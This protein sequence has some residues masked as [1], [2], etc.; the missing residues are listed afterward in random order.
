MH[1]TSGRHELTQH[2]LLL[3]HLS[4]QLQ[5]SAEDNEGAWTGRPTEEE[6]LAWEEQKQTREKLSTLMGQ[7]LLKGYRM[8]GSDC[9]SCAVRHFEPHLLACSHCASRK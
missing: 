2:S 9:Q 1:K 6:R 3:A 5:L 8:L 7:Y 4:L